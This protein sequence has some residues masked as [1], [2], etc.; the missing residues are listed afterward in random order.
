MRCSNSETFHRDPEGS[1]PSRQRPAN[2]PEASLACGGGNTIL[3][4]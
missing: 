1:T 2:Q 3:E 4:A